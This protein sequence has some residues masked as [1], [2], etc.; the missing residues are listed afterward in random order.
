MAMVIYVLSSPVR[1][2]QG[3]ASLV[4]GASLVLATTIAT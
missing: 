4:L 3:V 1:F 2:Q